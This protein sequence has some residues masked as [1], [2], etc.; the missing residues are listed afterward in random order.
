MDE[1]EV[2]YIFLSKLDVARRQLEVALKLFFNDND[3]VAIH[4]LVAA[5]HKVLF[6]LS[7][8]QGI[9]SIVKEDFLDTIAEDM[10]PIYFKR[11]TEAENFFKHA[12]KDGDKQLK[13]YFRGTEYLLYDAC[14][15]YRKLT[16]EK[17]G[18]FI[19]YDAWF[20][21]SH[22]HLI[23]NEEPKLLMDAIKELAVSLPADNRSAY[24]KLLPEIEAGQFKS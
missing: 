16:S 24:L 17:P 22:A 18:L 19:L 9:R 1:D 13:F 7:K 21:V 8:K 2:K 12:D 4:T 20:A 5:S 10:R 11:I 3:I 15:M 6:D 23:K 14:E